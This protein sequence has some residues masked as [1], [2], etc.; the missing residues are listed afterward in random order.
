MEEERP[1]VPDNQGE[2]NPQGVTPEATPTEAPPQEDLK[3]TEEQKSTTTVPTPEAV[4]VASAKI[5]E[6][7]H[8][9]LKKKLEISN[10]QVT[11]LQEE[12]NNL[13]QQL[14]EKDEKVSNLQS[15]EGEVNTLKTKVTE[16]E[17][18]ANTAKQEAAVAQQA[19]GEVDSLK[20]EIENLKGQL[21]SKSQ[22]VTDGQNR[23]QELS[24]KVNE[25]SEFG[26]PTDLKVLRVL[27]EKS[28]AN[29]IWKVIK[30]Q[31]SISLRKIAMQS[32][33]G[34]ASAKDYIEAFEQNGLIKVE[35]TGP[36][37]PDPKITL[38]P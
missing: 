31:R 23:I 4:P 32:G 11:E 34:A 29:D 22:E 15:L 20:S 36:D 16:L 3:P 7:E 5:S 18:E 38:K 17:A 24:S 9:E 35:S 1:N 30:D 25:M 12:I 14:S 19:S 2:E 26:D 33:M 8:E 6:A 10:S 28:P 37:D 13:K 21:E 27:A